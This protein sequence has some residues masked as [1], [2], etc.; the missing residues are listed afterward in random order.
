M[1]DRLAIVYAE[2]ARG[3]QPARTKRV[4]S[5]VGALAPSPPVVLAESEGPS[6]LRGHLALAK[7]PAGEIGVLFRLADGPCNEGP[8]CA[9]YATARLG[10]EPSVRGRMSLATVAPCARPL[11]GYAQA[12]G[13]WFYGLC[14]E[15]GGTARTGLFAIQFDPQYA[16]HEAVL[17]GCAPAGLATLGAAAVLA[18]RCGE[19]TRAV[20]QAAA[21]ESVRPIEGTRGVRCAAEGARLRLGPL[22]ASLGEVS[23]D[24]AAVLPEELAPPGSRAAWTGEA[25][26]VARYA[27]GRVALARY[28]CVS[29]RFTAL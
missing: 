27:E 23:G 10:S 24:L 2:A 13:V 22:E 5:D 7:G 16:V 6:D 21:T 19:A 3:E 12:G 25:L 29:G 26:L 14:S 17:P 15:E 18:G 9:R 28:G 20:V 1:G 4:L 11:A 8:R